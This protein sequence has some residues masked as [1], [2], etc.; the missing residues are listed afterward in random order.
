MTLVP[1]EI[2]L[3]GLPRALGGGLKREPVEELLK[4]VQWEYSQLYYELRAVKDELERGGQEG[5]SAEERQNG[6]ELAPL[7][8][9]LARRDA[10][11]ALLEEELRARDSELTVLRQKVAT[12]LSQP[13]SAEPSTMQTPEP[14]PRREVDELARLVLASAHKSSQELRQSTRRECELML[15]KTRRRVSI[16]EADLERIKALH[17]GELAE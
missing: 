16:M 12:Q 9:E 14:P 4:R 7:R 3:D 13:V 8:A 1:D 2:D 11:L 17:G 15:S 10:R 5:S 6:A